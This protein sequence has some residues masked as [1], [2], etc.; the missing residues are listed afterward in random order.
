MAARSAAKSRE[1]TPKEGKRYNDSHRHIAMQHI[2]RIAQKATIVDLCSCMAPMLFAGVR[3]DG[4]RVRN[5]GG[6]QAERQEQEHGAVG[7]RRV[8]AFRPPADQV[9]EGAR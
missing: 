1:E 2:H 5:E 4:L 9:D 8:T 6:G 7:A 3:V